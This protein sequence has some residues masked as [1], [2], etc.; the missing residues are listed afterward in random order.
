M[1]NKLDYGIEIEFLVPASNAGTPMTNHRMATVLTTAGIATYATNYGDTRA[2]PGK[3]KI[4]PD[5]SLRAPPGYV[6]MEL[7][8]PPMNESGLDDVRKACE[9]IGSL[10]AT[11]NK[12][13]GLHVHVG[14]RDLPFSALRKLAELYVRSELVM[15]SL[16]P[17]SRRGNTSSYARSMRHVR[18]DALANTRTAQDLVRLFGQDRFAKVNFAAVWKHGTV[19]FRHHSASVSADK[20]IKWIVMVNAMVDTAK[21]EANLPIVTSTGAE[22]ASD[23]RVLGQ[24]LRMMLRPE[25][26]TR[27]ELREALERKTS[28]DIRAELARAGISYRIDGRRNRREVYKYAPSAGEDTPATLATLAVKLGLSD[29]DIAYWTNRAAMFTPSGRVRP[30]VGAAS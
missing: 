14:A 21:K 10:G 25:G 8:S 4:K 11:V 24:L 28:V 2:M 5:G 27:L 30:V 26:V 12:S 29:E 19:E 15:D 17:N 20:I 18:M 6:G 16:M 22:P 23:R 1:S 9:V 3:W 7:V 13:C